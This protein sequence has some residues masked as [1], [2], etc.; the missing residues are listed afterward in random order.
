MHENEATLHLY[1]VKLLIWRRRGW[2]HVTTTTLPR[3]CGIAA[4]GGAAV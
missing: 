4:S 2:G 1:T 3:R